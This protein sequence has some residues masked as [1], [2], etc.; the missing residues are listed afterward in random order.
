LLINE[1]GAIVYIARNWI[2]DTDYIFKTLKDE[3]NWSQPTV[4]VYGKDYLTPR[5][6]FAAGDDGSNAYTYSGSN[7]SLVNWNESELASV[8]IMREIRDKILADEVIMDYTKNFHPNSCLVN[9][10]RDGN[11]G[12]GRHSD[13]ETFDP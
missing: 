4:K 6:Q 11:D 10:Y 8:K 13:K 9:Y 1:D 12:V 7:I 5:L 2:D 3:L